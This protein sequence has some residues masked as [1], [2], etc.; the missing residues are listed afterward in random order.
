[1]IDP[2][3]AVVV[4]PAPSSG[5]GTSG[6]GN[7]AGAA[8]AVVADGAIWLTYRVRR[9]DARGV[10]VVVARSDDGERFTTVTTV[11]RDLFGCESLE[12]PCLVRLDDGWRLYL[13]CATWDSKHWWVDSLTAP[14]V[15]A[16]AAGERAVVH[17]GSDDVGVKDPVVYRLP[18]GSFEMYLCCHPL[19]EPGAED[20]M[21][22]RYLT[23]PDGLAWTDHGVALAPRPGQW[24][25]R[26]VRVTCVLRRDPLT[27]LYDGRSDAASNW[28]ENTGIATGSPGQLTASAADPLRSPHSDG[29]L[30]YATAITLPDGTRR[31]YAEMANPDGSHDLVMVRMDAVGDLP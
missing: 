30:R 27:V 16:L 15:E 13:S 4:V 28:F 29:A 21:T 9:A 6:P 17:P 3:T 14:S 24:D 25:A 2:T 8:S 1:M 18:A 7:W 12:K 10:E 20:R 5:P 19:T 26:G 22:T 31:L 11:G 23:S